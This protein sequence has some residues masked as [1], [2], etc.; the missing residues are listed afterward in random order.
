M[1]QFQAHLYQLIEIFETM[2]GVKFARIASEGIESI[3]PLTSESIANHLSQCECGKKLLKS[4]DEWMNIK[5]EL[6]GK[7]YEHL[8]DY[9]PSLFSLSPSALCCIAGYRSTIRPDE[10]P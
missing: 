1:F 9:A 2:L 3:K 8:H 7:R 10:L 4:A 5:G 6:N